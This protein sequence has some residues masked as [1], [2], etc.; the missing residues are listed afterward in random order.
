MIPLPVDA[1]IDRIV[2]DL[3]RARAIVVTAAP[4]A[5]KTTRLPP[6]LTQDGPVI[7]LQPRRVAARSIASRIALERGWTLGREVG[8]QVRFD[9]KFSRDTQLLVVTEGILTARMQSDPFLTDF[10]TIVLD[11]FHERSIHADLAIALARQAWRARDDLRLVVM[12]ATLEAHSVSSYLDGCPVVDVPGRLHPLEI[13]HAPGQG[14]ADAAIDVLERTP[15]HVLCFL[16]GAGEIRR[17]AGDISSRVG[18]G[19]EVL[20]LHG[21]LTAA[22]Q[23]AAFAPATRRRIIAATN[24]AETSLT[25]PG[26]TGVVD[27]GLHKIARYDADRAI[28]SL[29]LERI[30]ADAADQRAGRA[31]REAPGVVR[32]LWDARDRLRPH[33][34][35]EIHRIDL[36]S[37]A[38]D[39][40]AWG[41]DPRQLEWFEAPSTDALD[42]AMAL[43][44]RLGLIHSGRLTAIGEQTRKL[45]LHPRLARMVVAGGGSRSIARTCALLSERHLFPP[46]PATTTSDL[47]S[48][49]DQWRELPPHVHRA[50]EQILAVQP[51]TRTSEVDEREFRRTILAG[52]PDR[53]ARRRE[54]QG[55]TFLL[56]TGTGATLARESGVRDA[57]FIVALDVQTAATQTSDGARRLRAGVASASHAAARGPVGRAEAGGPQP[58][59]PLIRM[60]SRIEREWLTPTSSS[61]EH[62]FDAVSGRVR[63]ARLDRYDAIVLAEHP[64]T[65]DPAVAAPMLAA[66]WLERG[67]RDADRVLLRRLAFAELAVDLPELVRHAAFSARTIDDLEIASALPPNVVR[68][69]ARDAPTRLTA[70]SGRTYALEYHDDGSVSAAVKLQEMFGVAETPRIGRRHTPLRLALLAPNG[71]PVQ[72][73]QDLRSFWERTYPEVRKELR[74]RYPKHKWPED[75]MGN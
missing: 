30:T 18:S 15:G 11:E 23:D 55:V 68:D 61:V 25:V 64:A 20:P 37:T 44:E 54:A 72:V 31:G 39:V 35:P 7:L 4:G 42:S 24:I 47:L 26:V 74:G 2:D 10:R 43:L 65:V 16:P 52:Y 22:E 38:L 46:H 50:A 51:A 12:S 45:P 19:I 62:R 17:A 6:A 13:S 56:A 8:W 70:P 53:V 75:G 71:R 36:S 40:I 5:G 1:F 3:R 9:H 66:A 32:R 57:G 14:V 60:A 49:L 69:L 21:A 73:T 48:A 29:D 33:R 58:S 34:E 63:A 59:D 27:T 41:G 28:D 67:P